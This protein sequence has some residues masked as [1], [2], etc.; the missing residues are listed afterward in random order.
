MVTIFFFKRPAISEG[1]VPEN[2]FGVK[3]DRLADVFP[4]NFFFMILGGQM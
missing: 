3:G 4:A 2:H 1:A